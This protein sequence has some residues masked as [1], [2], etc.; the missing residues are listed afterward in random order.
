MVLYP[1]EE[2]F[3]R[4]LP[5]VD[6]YIAETSD[7]LFNIFSKFDGSYVISWSLHKVPSEVLPLSVDNTFLPGFTFSTEQQHTMIRITHIFKSK[8]LSAFT[9]S[10]S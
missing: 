7:L 6:L 10:L 8:T 4:N 5:Y 3:L 2:P 1:T 9:Y